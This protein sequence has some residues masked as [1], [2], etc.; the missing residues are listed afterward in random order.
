MLSLCLGLA[1]PALCEDWRMYLHDP[2]HSSLNSA[3]SQINVNNI[4]RLG[5]NWTLSLGNG[6]ASS[7]TVVNGVLYFGD[8]EG[9]FYAVRASDGAILWQQ[10]LGK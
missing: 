4:N 6:L 1:G 10:W 9:N 5:Q 8:W 7:V 3:E 2:A